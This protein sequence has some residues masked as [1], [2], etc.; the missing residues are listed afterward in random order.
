MDHSE[1]NRHREITTFNIMM[2]KV[3]IMLHELMLKDFY[4]TE[5][6]GPVVSCC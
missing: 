5:E 4:A 3:M 6:S 1:I 2:K